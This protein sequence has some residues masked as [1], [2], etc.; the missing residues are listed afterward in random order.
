MVVGVECVAEFARIPPGHINGTLASSA[1]CHQATKHQTTNMEPPAP[2]KPLIDS[3]PQGAQE[4]MNSGGWLLVAGVVALIALLVLWLLLRGLLG[5]GKRRRRVADA[6]LTEDLSTYPPPP[7][8]WGDQ[9]LTVYDLPVRLRLV[10]AAPLGLEGGEVWENQIEWLLDQAAPGLGAM[11]R[12]DRPRV[13]V[14]PAQ[15]S[16]EGFAAAFRRHTLLPDDRVP[17][18]WVLLTG[19]ALIARRP[20]ALGLVFLANQDNTLGRITLDQPH[21]WMTVV[22]VKQAG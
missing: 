2:L 15:M 21:E 19:R 13:R 12:A 6:T 3:L 7:A 20:V 16:K 17:S 1:T 22:R 9:R 18:R 8:L 11:V 14:W 4:F 10:V 5:K